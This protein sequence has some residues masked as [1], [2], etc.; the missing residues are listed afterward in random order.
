MTL[1]P[2]FF[3]FKELVYGDGFVAECAIR[4]RAL[5]VQEEEREWWFNGIEPG[6]LAERG[7]TLNDA[8]YSFRDTLK[9]VLFDISYTTE[10]FDAFE[11]KV[12]RF[13]HDVNRPNDEDWWTCVEAGRKG[14]LQAPTPNMSEDDADKE[15]TVHVTLVDPAKVKPSGNELG[16]LEYA[17]LLA[18]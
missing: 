5:A 16:G 18:A 12:K 1:Y 17:R 9:E 6:G 7:E 14:E 13:M 11:A 4:G 8:Y 10:S 15:A 2:L 3:T